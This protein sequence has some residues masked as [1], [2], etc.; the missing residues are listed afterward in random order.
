[1]ASDP[2][3]PP[4]TKEPTFSLTAGTLIDGNTLRDY[5]TKVGA[6]LYKD[7]TSKLSTQLYDCSPDGYL[8]FMKSLKVRAEAF[9]WSEKD[10]PLWIEPKKGASKINLIANYGRITL[11]RTQ[12]GED[13]RMNQA[14]RLAQDNRA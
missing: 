12:E 7:A 11:E 6:T 2:Q 4:Y 14:T 8:Q 1:M 10:R 5:S 13:E 9:G 3:P